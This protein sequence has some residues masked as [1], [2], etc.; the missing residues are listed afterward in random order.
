[1]RIISSDLPK[2]RVVFSH[3][4]V[5]IEIHDFF[6]ED[7]KEPSVFA[8]DAEWKVWQTEMIKK[9]WDTYNHYDYYHTMT[10]TTEYVI[11]G[12]AY[13]VKVCEEISKGDL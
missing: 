13:I 11:D 1:M 10:I 4:D 7:D 5:G 2:Y 12:K 8:E 3:P 6:V 9:V